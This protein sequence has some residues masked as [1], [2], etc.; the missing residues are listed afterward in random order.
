[1][2]CGLPV[3][4][5]DVGGNAEVVCRPELGRVVPFGDAP[6][7]AGAIAAARGAAPKAVAL[8]H[9]LRT[10]GRGLLY[11]AFLNYAGG[12]LAPSHAML[13]HRDTVPGLS[14]GGAHVGMICDGSFPTSMLTHW[15]RDRTRGPKFALAEVV[16]MQTAD[17]ADAVGLFDRGRIRP[18]LRADLN[19][20]DYDGLTLKAPEVVY[21]LPAGGRRLIQRASGYLATI[22]A[23]QT[24]L[25]R[26]DRTP[27]FQSLHSI[28]LRQSFA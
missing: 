9:K 21:D 2:A 24:T 26:P 12:S 17:T 11:L 10:G 27:R 1:M 7:L 14:D 18:G 4:T 22:V 13:S 28:L 5:T 15:T 25:T 19:V 16:N 23:G 6:A 8:D 3:V 20:V